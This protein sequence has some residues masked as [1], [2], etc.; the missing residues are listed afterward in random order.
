MDRTKEQ[1][2]ADER[3]GKVAEPCP[4]LKAGAFDKLPDEIIQQYHNRA[5][6][7]FSLLIC[8]QNPF[9]HFS[10]CIRI[11]GSFEQEMATGISAGSAVRTP[12]KTMSI[13]FRCQPYGTIAGG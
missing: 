2:V 3:D 6:H 1:Y 7:Q 12:Y 4:S 9:S 13:L 8:M 11:I 10:R 5:K